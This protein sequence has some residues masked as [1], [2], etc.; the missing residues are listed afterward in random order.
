VGEL[1]SAY[2]A[3]ASPVPLGVLLRALSTLVAAGFVREAE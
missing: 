2:G 3:A 1:C